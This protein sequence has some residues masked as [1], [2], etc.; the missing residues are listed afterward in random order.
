M[1]I[2][3]FSYKGGR[4]KG[5]REEQEEASSDG[6]DVPFGAFISSV[7]PFQK[8]QLCRFRKRFKISSYRC[9]LNEFG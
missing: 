9:F 2:N 8:V 3:A 1:F 7:R 4:R 5:G 6:R